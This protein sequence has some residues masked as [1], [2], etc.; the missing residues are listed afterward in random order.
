MNTRLFAAM[1]VTAGT[2]L[3]S[4]SPPLL[5][6]I[7]YQLEFSASLTRI[8]RDGAAPPSLRTSRLSGG[9]RL[10][11]AVGPL[12]WSTYRVEQVAFAAA[13]KAAAAGDA[14]SLTGSGSYRRGGRGAPQESM[15]L[16]L[17]VSGEPVEVTSG[18]LP[19]AEDWP[20]IALVL[21]GSRL[22]GAAGTNREELEMSLQAVPVDRVTRHRLLPGSTFTDACDLC[23]R[24]DLVEPISGR[25]D[26]ALIAENPLV[27][28]F[29]MLDA[30]FEHRSGDAILRSLVGGGRYSVGGEVVVHR[31]LRLEVEESGFGGGRRATLTNN[32]AAPFLRWP[33]IHES[34]REAGGTP[35]SSFQIELWSAPIRALWFTTANGMTPGAF[36]PPIRRIAGGDL[37]DDTGRVVKSLEQLLA[38]LDLSPGTPAR[39]D[40]FTI[41]PGGGVWFSFAE[42][43]KTEKVGTIQEGDV[44]SDA[45][46][47]VF[48]NQELT[49][50]LGFMPVVPDL[51][52]DGLQVLPDG[53]VLFSTRWLQFSETL[54]VMVSPADIVSAAGA[55]LYRGEDLLAPFQPKG[56]IAEIGLD[57]F[58]VWPGGEVWFSAAQGFQSGVA[59]IGGVMDGDLLSSKGRIIY[60]NLD[61][62]R[63]F[64]PLEDLANFGLTGLFIVTDLGTSPRPPELKWSATNDGGW[65]VSWPGTGRVFQV[66]ETS[67]L[68]FPF[69]ARSPIGLERTFLWHPAGTQFLRVR[70]W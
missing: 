30:R 12:D 33:T 29:A 49:R 57:A 11:P 56:D 5:P 24:P 18:L 66:E 27:S 21:K 9:F 53:E 40:A 65:Q 62:V 13:G 1:A 47:R 14:V 69:V 48:T 26:L 70:A 45:G 23:G 22:S 37:L 19:A 10:V 63:E 61:L 38:P 34:L 36:P 28:R 31:S 41:A 46:R 67:D 51:G 3:T 4:A 59:E 8:P 64:Q 60:R 58:Y 20:A 2:L 16:T 50:N 32:P 35:R 44:V 55:V 17:D 6:G 43:V 39:L 7:P 15:T 25:Y 68:T 52:L 42:D 54:G